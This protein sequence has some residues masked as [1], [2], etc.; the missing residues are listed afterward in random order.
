MRTS[1]ISL[2]P[3]KWLLL[4]IP[5]AHRKLLGK[6]SRVLGIKEKQ[7]SSVV[8]SPYLSLA[9]GRLQLKRWVGVASSTVLRHPEGTTS[10]KDGGEGRRGMFIEG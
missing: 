6:S 3:R 9:L 5:Q 10:N 2:K 1:R 8:Q 7:P 4:P